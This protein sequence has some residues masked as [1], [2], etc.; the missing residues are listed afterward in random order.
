MRGA[1][2]PPQGER[3]S[4]TP[5]AP[6]HRVDA[7]LLASTHATKRVQVHRNR[8]TCSALHRRR[9]RQPLRHRGRSDSRNAR[10]PRRAHEPAMPPRWARQTRRELAA[11]NGGCVAGHTRQHAGEEAPTAARVARPRPRLRCRD[12]NT[13]AGFSPTASIAG[14]SRHEPGCAGTPAQ[15][16][17]ALAGV[18]SAYTANADRSG[19][20][21]ARGAGRARSAPVC[22]IPTLSDRM[23]HAA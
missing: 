19:R 15:L 5:I 4:A 17:P 1:L 14:P 21:R 16:L 2:E 13:P 8:S 20:V 9:A 22:A 6:L 18:T 12:V 11:L 23:G 3:I 10:Q 7:A